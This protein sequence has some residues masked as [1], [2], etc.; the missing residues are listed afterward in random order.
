MS[1]IY[2][3]YDGNYGSAEDCDFVIFDD[4]DMTDAQMR[5]LEED[6][7]GFYFCLTSGNWDLVEIEAN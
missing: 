7:S 3:G 6:P 1:K 4:T 2:V 5:L